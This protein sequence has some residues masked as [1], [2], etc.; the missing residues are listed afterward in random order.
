MFL[1]NPSTN[2]DHRPRLCL[3]KEQLCRVSSIVFG[4]PSDADPP[5]LLDS[6]QVRES[7]MTYF[8]NRARQAT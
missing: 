6:K 8:L 5:P 4:G 7:A 3:F 1:T 2:P